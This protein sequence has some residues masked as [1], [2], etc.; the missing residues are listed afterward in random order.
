MLVRKGEP[1]RPMTM[2]NA[3]TIK[4]V[5]ELLLKRGIEQRQGEPLGEYVSRGLDISPAEAESFLEA[6]REGCTV[7]EAQLRAGITVKS[8]K[9]GLLMD[10]ARAIGTTLGNIRK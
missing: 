7:E 1:F 8:E 2:I 5:Q 9:A 4:A 6:L 10:L 3:N